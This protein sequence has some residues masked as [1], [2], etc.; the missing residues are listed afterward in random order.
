M[1]DA[2]PFRALRYDPDL[3]PLEEVLAP[4]YDVVAAEDRAIYWDRHPHNALKLVL[5]RDVAEEA[6]TE[7]SEVA[8]TLKAWREEGV[9]KRDEQPAY[10]VLRQRFTAPDDRVLERVGFFAALQLE[11]YESRV[12]RPHERTL[13]GPKAD[14]LKILRAAEANL[15]SIFMLYED[16]DD[17]LA[18][19]FE[20]ALAD[21]AAI[22][23]SDDAGVEQTLVPVHDPAIAAE[24][25][26]FLQDRPVVIADGHHRYETALAYRDELRAG[27]APADHPSARTLAYFANAFAPGSLLLPIHRLVVGGDVPGPE[28]W[29][30]LE[31]AGWERRELRAESAEEIPGLLERELAPL[32]DRYAFA[33][34]DGSGTVVL[35]SRPAAS[36]LSV[37]IIHDEVLAEVF[38][39]DADAVRSG[40]VSFPKSAAQTAKDVREGRGKVALYLNPLSPDD[41]FRV[42][43]GRRNPPPEIDFLLSEAADRIAIPGPRERMTARPKREP[44]RVGGMVGTVLSEL[45]HSGAGEAFVLFDAWEAALGDLAQHAEPIDL[46]A[47]VLEVAVVSPV[48]A[49]HL[50]LRQTQILQ[51]LQE[52]MGPKAPT[53]LRFLVRDRV[54]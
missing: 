37:R 24:I 9:L 13:A 36:E 14:R 31:A 39:L 41:V 21:P 8:E 11:D 6:S 2:Q 12:V 28:A 4:V 17:K 25:G 46:K 20:T 10:Y 30:R 29:A 18:A 5:T 23:V 34:D 16:R 7:Y 40:A 50:Q 3:A 27:G 35:W 42:T 53:E 38:A 47:G 43:E 52:E 22:V 15:S 49:Q 45:G 44:S 48:W 1:T 33:A 51:A 19:I 32:S 54:R 26:R